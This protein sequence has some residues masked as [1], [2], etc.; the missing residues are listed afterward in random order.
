MSWG[1][2]NNQR[3]VYYVAVI[4]VV[5][6]LAGGVVLS[7]KI[8]FGAFTEDQLNSSTTSQ[9]N[10]NNSDK[11]TI[12]ARFNT[13]VTADQVQ[14]ISLAAA[15]AAVDPRIK[16]VDPRILAVDPRI[17]DNA[18]TYIISYSQAIDPKAF[19]EALRKYHEVAAADTTTLPVLDRVVVRFKPGT[20]AQAHATALSVVTATKDNNRSLPQLDEAVLTLPQATVKD[21][22]SAITKLKA[23]PNIT[24]AEPDYY[25]KATFTPNDP[26]FSYQYGLTKIHA[27]EAWDLTQGSTAVTIADLDTGIVPF[28]GTVIR[29]R[30]TGTST[31]TED[32]LHKIVGSYNAITHTSCHPTKYNNTHYCTYDDNGHGTMTAGVAAVSTNNNVG[33][34]GAGFNSSLIIVKV[35]DGSGSGTYTDVAAGIVWATDHGAKVINMSLGGSQP[36]SDLEAA[37]NYAWNHGVVVIAAA[38]NNGIDSPFYPAYYTNVI[39]AA[40]TDQND[41]LASFSQYGSWV[42]VAAPGVNIATTMPSSNGFYGY[43]SGTSFSAPF[44][45]GEA[46]L[47]WSK[48][49]TLTNVQVR[50]RIESSTDGTYPTIGH[51]RINAFRALQ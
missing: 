11:E 42:D 22:D 37:V 26:S 32:F 7:Q 12:L 25:A 2:L 31:P 21:Q 47:I 28:D 36:S 3:K 35:L 20:T 23:D 38:G 39:A 1:A 49:P 41:A 9:S 13:G 18:N 24:S 4:A 33:V 48:Y 29:D 50:Q 19:I 14:T 44:V 17:R 43:G 46:A 51:G 15:A 10:A 5:V 45:S 27:P 40:A 30:N 6:L 16:A 8:N 34:A